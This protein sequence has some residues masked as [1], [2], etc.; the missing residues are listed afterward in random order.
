MRGASFAFRK[1]VRTLRYRR[2]FG[3]G[4]AIASVL[5]PFCMGAVAGGIA[6]GQVPSGGR[7][8]DPVHSWLNPT[9]VLTGVL[10]VAV[11]AYLAAVYLVL[12]ARRADDTE[13]VEY[14]RRRAVLAAAVA[15]VLARHRPGDRALR[16]LLRLRRAHITRPARG[17]AQRRVRRRSPG[18]APARRRPWR[19]RAGRGGG[20]RP[21]PL[22]GSGAVA[23]PP[24]RDAHRP[25]RGRAHRDAGRPGRCRRAGARCS[26]CPASSS[27]TRSYSTRC[28]PTRESRTWAIVRSESPPPEADHL[29]RVRRRCAGRSSVNNERRRLA[30]ECEG[31]RT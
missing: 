6:S 13:M 2:I 31:V 7:A 25:G 14:F 22:L 15:A 20:R 8:G 10:A 17:A 27:C 18:A 1:S 29:P 5:V 12:D 26:C 23:L 9:S 21:H 19:T 28:C 16:R 4:F 30:R 24:A 11:A 3:G